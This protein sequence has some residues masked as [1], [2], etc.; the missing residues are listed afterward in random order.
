MPSLNRGRVRVSKSENSSHSTGKC[1]D[2][3][4]EHYVPSFQVAVR[5][6]SFACHV[7]IVIP[8]DRTL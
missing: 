8:A 2:S 7:A 5:N 6:R 1:I 4:E 3:S